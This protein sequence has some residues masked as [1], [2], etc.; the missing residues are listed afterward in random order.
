[1]AP[2]E[3]PRQVWMWSRVDGSVT[4]HRVRPA[5]RQDCWIEEWPLGWNQYPETHLCNSPDEAARQAR[6]HF[7]RIMQRTQAVLARLADP[8]PCRQE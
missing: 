4:R 3:G 5:G 7:E 6:E 2:K 1:M 8:A